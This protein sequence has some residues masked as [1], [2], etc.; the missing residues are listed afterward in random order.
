MTIFTQNAKMKKTSKLTGVSVFNFGIPAYKSVTGL[1]TCPMADKCIKGCY[2]K[3][4][5]YMFTTSVNSYEN[6]LALTQL[7]SFEAIIKLEIDKLLL[8]HNKVVIRIH[9]SGDFYSKKYADKWL[10]ICIHY[11]FNPNIQ[12]YAYT[13]MVSMFKNKSLPINLTLIYS[14]GGLQDNL[15]DVDTMNHAKVFASEA[16]LNAAGYVN[17]S[18][19]DLLVLTNKRIGLVY[20]G[21]K[22]YDKTDWGSVNGHDTEQQEKAS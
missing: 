10:S 7:D 6:R 22:R 14:F 17:A 4:G 9:D 15:I 8:K 5:C 21:V 12:F 3:Q 18:N 1:K 11:G 19:N 20:H 16:E 2:A 13:K